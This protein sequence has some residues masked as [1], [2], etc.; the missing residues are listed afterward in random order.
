MRTSKWWCKL[1]HGWY[2]GV[3]WIDCFY[4]VRFTMYE[5]Y[6]CKKIRFIEEAPDEP[7]T[8]AGGDD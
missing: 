7:K 6:A 8:G 1:F 3:E 5:C 2:H 4:G